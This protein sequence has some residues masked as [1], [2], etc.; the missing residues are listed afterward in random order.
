MIDSATDPVWF[1]WPVT[2]AIVGAIAVHRLLRRRAWWSAA[3]AM[4]SVAVPVLPLTLAIPIR[5]SDEDAVPDL[6]IVALGLG[7]LGIVGWLAILARLQERAGD[8]RADAERKTL[9]SG[10]LLVPGMLVEFVASAITLA[11][12]CSGTSEPVIAHLAVA[13]LVFAVVAGS[14]LLRDRVDQ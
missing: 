3:V 7:L 9:W 8:T 13:A 6:R 1:F 5:C 11:V 4:V 12:R 10:A 2:F 14:A